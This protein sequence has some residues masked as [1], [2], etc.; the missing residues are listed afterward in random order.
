MKYEVAIGDVHGENFML[1]ELLQ[2]VRQ[3]CGADPFQL[4]FLGDYPD[5][6]PDSKRVIETVRYL[7]GQGA[8]ALQG[9]HEE[10]FFESVLNGN[11]G[12]REVW[13]AHGGIQSRASYGVLMPMARASH[14]YTSAEHADAKWMQ[15]LPLTHE[16][17]HRIYLHAGFT[18]GKPL[19]GQSREMLQWARPHDFTDY[20]MDT[21]QPGKHVVFGHT[22]NKTRTPWLD[23]SWTGIDTGACFPRGALSAAI[24]LADQP[25]GPISVLRVD[26]P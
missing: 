11:Q 5:R 9:N 23:K 10:L 6:G 25:G 19:A 7:Q 18:P 21:M 24:F 26:R 15:S 20:D 13:M 1:T 4:I 3:R 2:L 12:A 8:I 17:K 16:T 14:N 22:P